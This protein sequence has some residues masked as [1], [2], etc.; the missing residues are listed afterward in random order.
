MYLAAYLYFVDG[1]GAGDG[2]NEAQHDED[3]H[4]F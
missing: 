2:Q 3:F 1:C 4:S